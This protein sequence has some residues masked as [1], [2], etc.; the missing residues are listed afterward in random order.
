[1]NSLKIVQTKTNPLANIPPKELLKKTKRMYNAGLLMQA[2]AIKIAIDN[3]LH[4]LAPYIDEV[5][6]VK[7]EFGLEMQRYYELKRVAGAFEDFY[8][9]N[10][11]MLASNSDRSEKPETEDVSFEEIESLGTRRIIAL[12]RL[13]KEAVNEI[14]EKGEVE[15][16]G[17]RLLLEDAKAWP[18]VDLQKFI[19]TVVSQEAKKPATDKRDK[20]YAD[21]KVE[22]HK[23]LFH[24]AQL[25]KK[26]QMPYEA[27]RE[28]GATIKPVLDPWVEKHLVK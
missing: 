10:H 4:L 21:Q 18:T 2:F 20:T 3:Q 17:R 13:G 11:F 8:S 24:F 5:D 19:A 15:L 1:M 26:S 12:S 27:L 6:F 28:F 7:K 14:F 23:A 9:S 22:M 25:M 16:H